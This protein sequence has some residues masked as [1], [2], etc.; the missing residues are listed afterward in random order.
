MRSPR[1]LK[2]LTLLAIVVVSGLTLLAWTQTWFTV[3]VSEASTPHAQLTVDGSLAAP[4]LAALSLAGFALV[5]AL[6]IAGPF[7]RIVLGVLQA[8]IGATV[9]LTASVSLG[10]PV[11]ASAAAVTKATGISGHESIA[12]LVTS[13]SV[14]AWPVIAVVLGALTVLLGIVVIVTFRLWPTSSRRYQ[15]VRLEEADTTGNA[16][17]DWDRL[18][19]GRDPTAR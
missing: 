7:F 8:L 18:S 17:S 19:D 10:N 5:A 13:T 15:A 4:A 9:V 6:A 16:V 2:L 3:T 1:R 14:T 11:I 12:R